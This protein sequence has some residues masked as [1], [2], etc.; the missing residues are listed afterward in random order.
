MLVSPE[1]ITRYTCDL[2]IALGATRDNASVVAGHL[3]S[4]SLMG[5]HSHGVIRIPQYADDI[6]RGQLDPSAVP[7][8]TSRFGACAAVDGH[9]GFGQVTALFATTEAIALARQAGVGLATARN[10]GH[11]GRMGAYVEEI[12]RAGMIGIAVCGGSRDPSGH[13]VAPF[14]GKQGRLSTNPLAFAFPIAGG[15]PVVSDFAT[16]T[17][18][19][20]VVRSWH[21][22]GLA[23][24]PGTLRDSA[25]SPTTDPA[26]LYTDPHGT[27]EPVGGPI[28][29]Y[30]GTAIGIL[31][32]VL[33]MVSLNGPAADEQGGGVTILAIRVD[34]RFMEGSRWL[35][36]YVRSC[37]PIDPAKPVLMPGDRERAVAERTDGV[38]VDDPTWKALSELAKQTGVS[39]PVPLAGLN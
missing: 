4:S 1:G 25:G 19:E 8:V 35:A 14:G 13:W 39:L 9:T 6:D 20:G 38:L 34:G 18:A 29:G 32:D 28:Y 22:R 33:S 21:N 5:V 3:V 27:I 10:L 36:D 17:T 12:A 24:P 23:A 26:C 37:E 31:I 11:T 30:K 2:F 16:S 15:P 7:N